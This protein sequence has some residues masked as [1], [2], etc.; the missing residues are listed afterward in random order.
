M[1]TPEPR[2][3]LIAT[4]A[5]D[6]P[7]GTDLYTRDLAVTLQRRGVQPVVYAT[8][9]GALRRSVRNA[10]VPVVSDVADL[11]AAPDV[12]HGHHHLETIAAMARFPGVPALFVCHD[13]ISWHSIPPRGPRLRAYVA[14]DRNCRDRMMFEHGIPERDIRIFANAVDLERFPRRGPLPE[15]PRRALVFSNSAAENTFAAPIR[16]ACARRG[17]AV[18]LAGVASGNVIVPENVLRDYDVVFAKG[19]SALEAMA[20][21]CAVV[22]ADLRGIGGMVTTERLD[23][24]RVLNFGHRLLDTPTTVESVLAELDR[25]DPADAAPV[26]DRIRAS[27][28]VD[29]LAQ[30]YIE[31]YEELLAS[32]IDVDPRDDL[33]AI[34]A[35]LA[36][37]TPHLYAQAPR[38]A[39]PW[40]VRLLNAR[41]LRMPVQ[42]LLRVRRRLR[43]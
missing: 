40:R 3:I 26:T 20:S 1:S 14:V 15:K 35:S 23:A 9:V 7:S 30:Q 38:A 25:Y 11:A 17:I 4:A 21:G 27:A 41:A 42:L 19:R 28:G 33:A 39:S 10:S 32:P 36:H 43:G 37:V 13:A 24:M 8:R 18:D 31:L 34:G 5:L 6:A 12:I 22:A 2:R 16:D 29:L